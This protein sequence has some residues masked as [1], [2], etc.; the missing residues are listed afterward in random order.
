MNLPNYNELTEF[1]KWAIFYVMKNEK[2][3][4]SLK[5]IMKGMYSTLKITID[6]E[7]YDKELN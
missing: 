7:N 3:P 5:G 1:Q 2:M 4:V 6:L